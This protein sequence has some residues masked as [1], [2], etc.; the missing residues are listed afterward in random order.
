MS[1]SRFGIRAGRTLKPAS[2]SSGNAFVSETGGLTFKSRA[3][4]LNKELPTDR[5]RCDVSSK[6]AVLSAS[7][8]TRWTR[9]TC[10]TF[11]RNREYNERLD[12]NLRILK[13]AH[14]KQFNLCE[15]G[16]VLRYLA[17]QLKL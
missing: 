11:R 14:A 3:V 6:R 15:G 8:I 1:F 17:S 5:H 12:F 13:I 16:Q 4:K 10:Y 2:W 7:V 9:K